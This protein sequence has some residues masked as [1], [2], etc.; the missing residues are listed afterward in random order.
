[1]KDKT[2]KVKDHSEAMTF[3]DH[4][5]ELRWR[6]IKALIA[7]VIVAI[8]C[9]IYW[10]QIIELIMIYPIRDIDPRPQLMYTSPT[11]TVILSF[12]IAL[13]GGLIVASPVIFYQLWRF[14]A[15]GLYMNEKRII[16]PSVVI[17]TLCFLSGISFCYLTL[18]IVLKFLNAFGSDT[19]T[20]MY[21][22]DE[23]FSFLLKLSLAFGTVFELPVISFLLARTGIITGAFL[24]KNIKYAIV[25]IFVVAA[26]LTPPDIL[27]QT[28]L[29]L[30]LFVLY[31]ISIIVAYV[32]QKKKNTGTDTI[33]VLDA[34]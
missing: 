33:P 34:E 31:G 15:P 8:P 1:M 28:M 9:G 20:A 21:K 23:Y 14:I 24:V 4:L 18:P 22:I 19:L 32:S 25:V 26:V 7:V 13:F 2:K 17:S 10:Q 29:A 11:A 6:V 30:P 5:E 3:L 16:L 12:K 27:S